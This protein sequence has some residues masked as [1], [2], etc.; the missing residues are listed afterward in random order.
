MKIKILP[1]IISNKIAAGEVVER[2]SSVV[3]ELLENA[4]DAGSTQILIE[5]EKGGKSLIRVSDNGA[6]M[7]RDDALLS[8]ER[9]ATSKISKDE[10]LFSISTFG[11]RGEA[12]P[13]IASVSRFVLVT[14]ENSA[15]AGIEIKIDGGRILSVA[16]K[17]SP[18]GTM[19]TVKDLFFNTPARRKFL[20]STDTEM[21][22][23]A[24]TVASMALGHTGVH[25][26][27]LNNGKTVYNLLSAPDLAQRAEDIL[28]KDTRSSLYRLGFSS[29][30]I[31]VS[32]WISSP[33]IKRATTRGIY[34][35]V[36][37]RFVRDRV[38]QHALLEGYETRL[39]KGEFPVAVIFTKLPYDE[40]DVNV[41]PAKREVRFSDR[42]KVHEAVKT[43]VKNTLDLL[44]PYKKAAADFMQKER[45]GKASGISEPLAFYKSDG[46]DSYLHPDPPPSV[47][48]P[49]IAA[50]DQSDNGTGE[51][52]KASDMQADLWEKK[53]FRD[54][55]ILGQFHGTYIICESGE[56]IFLIDQHAAHERILYEELKIRAGRKEGHPSQKLL[57]PEIIEF[58]YREAGIFEKLLPDFIS[59]GI[60][61]EPF[62][63][64]AFAVKSVPVFMA[65]K[66]IKAVVTEIVEKIIETG[67]ATGLEKA[68]DEVLKLVACHGAIRANQNLSDKEIRTLVDQLDGCTMPSH[69]PHG[70]PTWISF[71]I[72]ELEKFFK[73]IG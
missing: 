47:L 55:R 52:K 50:A 44:D 41:H 1:E 15:E 69:C 51:L 58:G 37:W 35:Y 7:G 12:L 34:T 18:S 63:G 17:G 61:V 33:M 8:I 66:D 22:H 49:N 14:K 20:K 6:G 65:G 43:A 9:Y 27:L 31:S 2:P 5:I 72:N 64:N 16:D 68:S 57:V 26:R 45:T 71:T 24:D 19:V 4:L 60:E 23:I 13:S 46:K 39:I 21:G 42:N 73:R 54:L 10:D 29:G 40:V 32:G 30:D 56:G 28:G 48:S 11:F 38:I 25:F 36:N 3:K 67:F 59:A 70:R 53:Q 62:G